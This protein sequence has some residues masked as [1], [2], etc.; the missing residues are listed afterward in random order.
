MPSA[1]QALRTLRAVLIE[2]SGKILTAFQ[3]PSGF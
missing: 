3:T 1:N 2:A